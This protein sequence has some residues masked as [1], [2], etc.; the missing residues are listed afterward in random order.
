DRLGVHRLGAQECQ[1]VCMAHVELD[2]RKSLATG[3]E[4]VESFHLPVG[5]DKHVA[6]GT[7]TNRLTVALAAHNHPRYIFQIVNL[8]FHGA[9]KPPMVENGDEKICARRWAI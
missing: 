2:S 9:L 3:A 4:I 8:Q 1:E 7:I 6:G 5:L